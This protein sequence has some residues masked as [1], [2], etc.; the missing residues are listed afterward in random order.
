MITFGILTFI[1]IC[2]GSGALYQYAS[3][4]I[5]AK[6][7]PPLGKLVDIGG[8]RLHIYCTGNDDD[9]NIS[10]QQPTVIL[11]AGLSYDSLEWLLV[12]PEIAKF[13]RVCSY[14]RAGYGWS[15]E[16]SNLRTSKNIV[17]ELHTL[18][19][20]AKITPP[21]ILVGHSFGGIN[22]QIYAKK[23]PAEV[24][25][26]ILVDSG[27]EKMPAKLPAEPEKSWLAKYFSSPQFY[28][29]ITRMG[30]LRFWKGKL[31]L[32]RVAHSTLNMFP[33]KTQQLLT[34]HICSE[35]YVK[36]FFQEKMHFK[37]HL[38]ELT[39]VNPVFGNM[40]LIVITAGMTPAAK[41]M[42]KEWQ[43]YFKQWYTAWL[44]LQQ[45]LAT[46]S[47]N[48]KHMIAENSGHMIPWQQPEIIVQAVREIIKK[49]EYDIHTG[50]P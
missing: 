9:K 10:K 5:D 6:Q 44:A 33:K 23:Y 30:I 19:T 48:S 7:Y 45:D 16:N 21:Y 17:E 50:T 18:L 8:C 24:A 49:M 15:D 27:Q 39:A 4:K 22:M 29:P 3:V 35:K 47:S 38:A 42:P 12:Q 37:E 46:R 31:P 25:G 32:P 13:A 1:L 36:T 28:L 34:T 2:V 26:L 14:D 20:N 40:P 11:D 41:G 43:E